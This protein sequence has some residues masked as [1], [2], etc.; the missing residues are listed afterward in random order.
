MTL[1]AVKHPDHMNGWIVTCT[2][3][4]KTWFVFCR[5]DSNTEAD[6]VKIVTEVC[7]PTE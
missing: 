2:E 3:T 6:A 5:E 7:A 4:Q 1:L